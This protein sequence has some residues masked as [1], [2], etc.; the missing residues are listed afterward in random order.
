MLEPRFYGGR[1]LVRGFSPFLPR[2]G[3]FRWESRLE[4]RNANPQGTLVF[5]AGARDY[6]PLNS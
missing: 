5:I 4:P 6:S 2:S 3:G 1:T